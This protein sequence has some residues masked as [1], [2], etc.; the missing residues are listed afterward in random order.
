M[1]ALLN[2]P[3]RQNTVYIMCELLCYAWALINMRVQAGYEVLGAYRLR[4]AYHLSIIKLTRVHM[5]APE[6]ERGKQSWQVELVCKLIQSLPGT[7]PRCTLVHEC[8]IFVRVASLQDVTVSPT[9]S[10]LQR[11]YAFC[12]CVCVRV[13]VICGCCCVWA[14][15]CEELQHSSKLFAHQQQQQQQQEERQR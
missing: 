1:F 11:G 14:F 2:I 12:A 5:V 4:R 9:D 15:T 3:K 7:L 6:L 10:W 8:T 13:C